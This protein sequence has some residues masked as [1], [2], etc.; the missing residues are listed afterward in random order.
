LSQISP[1][2]FSVFLRNNDRYLIS[3]SPERF[4]KK[5]NG[6]LLSQPI[7]GTARRVEDPLMDEQ[8]KS[9]LRSSEKELSENMMIVD[10]VR[11]DLAKS[12]VPGSVKVDELFGIYSFPQI[13]QMISTVSSEI[14]NDL[15]PI[16]AIKNA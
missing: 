8:V 11:N 4:L 16:D 3:A 14:R 7:K 6:K 10:L 2:P 9:E 13:H 1:A 12:S 5:E 15:H